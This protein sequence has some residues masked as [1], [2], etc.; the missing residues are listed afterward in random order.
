MITCCDFISLHLF[1]LY[2]DGAP[3]L[4]L[5]PQ[6]ITQVRQGSDEKRCV[7]HR[8]STHYAPIVV[9]SVLS[10]QSVAANLIENHFSTI[11]V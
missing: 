8:Y 6:Q 3:W 4:V 10:L 1:R 9:F 7:K 11:A 2:V 5:R